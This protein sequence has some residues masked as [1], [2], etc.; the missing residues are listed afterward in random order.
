ME[1]ETSDAIIVFFVNNQKK[2]KKEVY[3]YKKGN[4]PIG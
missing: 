4:K 1:L 3:K 2:R